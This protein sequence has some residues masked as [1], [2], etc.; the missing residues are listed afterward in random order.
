MSHEYLNK[1]IRRF[2]VYDGI[3]LEWYDSVAGILRPIGI[4]REHRK[5]FD[6]SAWALDGSAY[7]VKAME[8]EIEELVRS[9]MFKPG[10]MKG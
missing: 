2:T 9:Y 3:T 1:R 6:N 5:H 8:T 10:K 7:R 4:R